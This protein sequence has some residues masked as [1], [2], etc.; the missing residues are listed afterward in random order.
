MAIVAMTAFVLAAVMPAAGAQ[1]GIID[2]AVD[3]LQG[4]CWPCGILSSI[5][6]NGLTLGNTLFVGLASTVRDLLGI[7]VALW[8]VLLAARILVPFG[9]EGG[10]GDLWNKGAKK[11]LLLSL[12]IGFLQS[13]TPFWDYVFVPVVGAG[14][15]LAGDISTAGGATGT[16]CSTPTSPASGLAGAKQV[17]QGIECP[18]TR[19][20]DTFGKGIVAGIAIMVHGGNAMTSSGGGSWFLPSLPNVGDVLGGLVL[21]ICGLGVSVIYL[22]GLVMFPLAIVD[23][24]LRAVVIATLSPMLI[25]ATVFA[26]T[27]GAAEAAFRGLVHA[28]LT[29]I[30]VAVVANLG[31][32]AIDAVFASL[33]L[34]DWSNV[35]ALD[36]ANTVPIWSASYWVL[37]GVGIVLL[38]MMKHANSMAAE[39]SKAPAGDFSGAASGAFAVGA[40]G[41]AAAVGGVK[42]ATNVLQKS[43]EGREKIKKATAGR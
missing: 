16:A 7:L 18:L 36:E 29:L 37:L 26:W 22:L 35:R 43:A 19:V 11:L 41:V 5:S 15:A 6:D 39:F 20:Q 2:D 30:L 4:K 21:V 42:G 32:K 9:P 23:V 17:M 28:G 25:A 31:S 27:R 3:G 10:V 33:G 1:A 40:A 34:G 38:F 14:V 8:I 12:V 24:V 13:A